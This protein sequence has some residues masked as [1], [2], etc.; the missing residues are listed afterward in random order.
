MNSFKFKNKVNMDTH[1][2][3]SLSE[4]MSVKGDYVNLSWT[5]EFQGRDISGVK[6]AFRNV[7]VPGYNEEDR[8]QKD[9]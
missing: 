1:A 5:T 8:F 3:A 6:S 2:S 7:A 4:Q 9:V